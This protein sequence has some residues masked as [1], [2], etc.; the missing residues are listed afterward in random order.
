MHYE[1]SYALKMKPNGVRDISAEISE[2]HFGHSSAF[3]EDI[4]TKLILTLFS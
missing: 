4:S 2:P 1:Y 3:M